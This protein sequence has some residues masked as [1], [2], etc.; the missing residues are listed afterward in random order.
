MA[1]PKGLQL[2]PSTGVLVLAVG[3]ALLAA[4]LV[5]IYIGYAKS[6]YQMGSKTFLQLQEDV[7]K[8]AP[9]MD[10]HLRPILVPKPILSAF[11]RAV[12]AEDKDGVVIGKRAPRKL[13]K[14]QILFYADF[15]QEVGE[16]GGLNPQKGYEL[17][18]IP[19][20]PDNA[21]GRQLQPGSYVTVYG[22]FNVDPDPKKEDIRVLPVLSYVQVRALAGLTT[23][24]EPGKAIAYDNI[25]VVVRES[26]VRQL[27]QIQKLLKF[28]R[29]TLTM[30]HTPEG[31]ESKMEPEINKEVLALIE[32]TRLPVGAALPAP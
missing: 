3:A 5:N 4:V 32:K 22:D 21:L 9:M 6:E 13:H 25:Q 15:I 28:R 17:F 20:S 24:P 19:I 12:K 30:A 10:R 8:G 26:Q 1:N 29:F 7:E 2:I 11:E 31:S 27:L 16:E 18:T 14:G 23:A